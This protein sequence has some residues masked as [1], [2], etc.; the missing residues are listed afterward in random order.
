MSY[1]DVEAG[2]EDEAADNTFLTFHVGGEEYAVPVAQV[3]EIV[4][5]Q[6]TYAVPDVPPY[7]RGV[8]NLRGKV[9]PLLDVRCRFGLAEE[10]YTDRTVVVV[11]EVG[12]APTG[13]VVDGVSD[14][15][16][17]SPEQI[18]PCA[19]TQRRGKQ[20]MVTGMGKRDTKVSFILDLAALLNIDTPPQVSEAGIPTH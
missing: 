14:V 4:R 18:E 19:V 11:L 8:M 16:E 2:L 9:I 3:T 10:V 13:L 7:V 15:T 5:L 6:K 17:I 12:D 1:D 20:A